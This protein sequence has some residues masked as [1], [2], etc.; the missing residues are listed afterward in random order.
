MAAFITAVV[1]A[2]QAVAAWIGTS[3]IAKTVFNIAASF[4]VSRLINKSANKS[5]SSS[6]G[7]RIQLPPQS[8]NKIPVLYGS[9]YINGI[10][11][12]ARLVSTDSK[13]NNVM[14][15][16][17]VLSE[18]TNTGTVGVDN[19]YWSDVK[20]VFES[21]NE[22]THKVLKGVKT[23]DTTD[24]Y[25]DNNFKSESTNLVQIRVYAGNTES[26]QQIFPQNNKVNAYDF[27]PTDAN[28]NKY[29]NNALYGGKV[30]M[31]GLVFAIVRV[32]YNQEKGIT[33]LPNITFKLNNTLNNPADVWYDYM[34]SNRYGANVNTAE[35]DSTALS[36]WRTH[37]NQYYN[38][39]TSQWQ[40]NAIGGQLPRYQ[41]N[42][43]VDTGNPVKN[44][45]DQILQ[46][47]AAWMSYD[48][49]AGL[50][51]VYP[52]APQ[53]ATLTFDD[54]NIVGGIEL[55]STNLEDLFNMLEVEYCDTSNFDQRLY[56]RDSIPV[57]DANN[58]AGTRHPNEPDNKLSMT[59]DLINNNIQA[60]RVGRIQLK[61]TRDDLVIRFNASHVGL[62]AQAGDV[63]YVKNSLYNWNTGTFANGKPFRITRVKEMETQDGALVVEITALE[64]NED[65]YTE[66]ATSAFTPSEN[67][68]IAPIV[69]IQQPTTPTIAVSETSGRPKITVTSVVPAGVV[70]AMEYWI[71]FDVGLQESQR[72]YKLMRV[73][74]PASGGTYITGTQVVFDFD[75]LDSSNLI[76]K[77]RGVNRIGAGPFSTVSATTTFTPKPVASV[78]D[79]N[80]ALVDSGGA[81]VGDLSLPTLLGKVADTFTA[82]DGNKT[83]ADK[84]FEEFTQK[85]GFDI[86]KAAT[87][88]SLTGTSG[89]VDPEPSYIPTITNV[90]PTT[91][92]YLGDT[93]VT[94]T[95]TNFI[96]NIQG[97]TIVTEL[98]WNDVVTATTSVTTTQIIFPVPASELGNN[99]IKVQTK[100]TRNGI[101]TTY[102][103]AGY[104]ITA[105]KVKDLKML[106]LYP[107]SRSRSNYTVSE[108]NLN[109]VPATGSYF[110]SY[111][112]DTELIV[113][114]EY[115][116]T[117]AVTYVES[118]PKPKPGD[119][120]TITFGSNTIL[121][122]FDVEILQ[123]ISNDGS[124][125]FNN[126]DK[127]LITN[128]YLNLKDRNGLSIS[129]QFSK[130]SAGTILSITGS[131]NVDN[132]LKFSV[133]AKSSQDITF[134]DFNTL[135]AATEFTGY[136]RGQFALTQEEEWY[137]M[138]DGDKFLTPIQKTYDSIAELQ[139]DVPPEDIAINQYARILADDPNDE[140]NNKIYLWD[141]E[142][143]VYQPD[144]LYGVI[145]T[146]F[147][148]SE[149][150]LLGTSNP[151]MRVGEY[152]MV[153]TETKNVGNGKVYKW[154]G[155]SKKFVYQPNIL[156]NF[157][158]NTNI[159]Q[160]LTAYQ[161]SAKL[162]RADGTLY[163]TKT[164]QQ[165]TIHNN[166][167]EIPFK[168]R[169]YGVDYYIMLDRGLVKSSDNVLSEEVQDNTTWTFTTE[170]FFNY[171]YQLI[172][173]FPNQGWN[174]TA[175]E[176]QFFGD[177]PNLYFP[178]KK[179]PITQTGNEVKGS[180]V[181][182]NNDNS[183]IKEARI[184]V[185]FLN[186]LEILSGNI[187][188][189]KIFDNTIIA[190]IPVTDGIINNN[191]AFEIPY[192]IPN[193]QP[194]TR[195][196]VTLPQGALSLIST[197]NDL[198]IGVNA[199]YTWTFKTM[200][201][202]ELL[203]YNLDSSKISDPNLEFVNR[204]SNIKLKFG[205]KIYKTDVIQDDTLYEMTGATDPGDIGISDTPPAGA[206]VRLY[207]KTRDQLVEQIDF[208]KTFAAN[209]VGVQYN[210]SLGVLT[211]NFTESFD[212]DTE[213]YILFNN[214]VYDEY[215]ETGDLGSTDPNAV[216]FTTDGVKITHVGHDLDIVKG[217]FTIGFNY[218][219]VA[220]YGKLRI[221]DLTTNKVIDEFRADDVASTFYNQA[222][223]KGVPYSKVRID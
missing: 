216:K 139:A 141:G 124:L 97:A 178:I 127:T 208:D 202:V 175:A 128:I 121:S 130:I 136:K 64:Y 218:P 210:S 2:V 100:A 115:Y 30:G 83:L 182:N 142:K 42:G 18:L 174:T 181:I 39:S 176:Q 105:I 103:S 34:T 7:G 63:V 59:L 191:G 122:Y 90:T 159:E 76:V 196:S 19:I 29:W 52:Q 32:E 8:N 140:D 94:V 12:D 180:V 35:I 160:A 129:N 70:E 188:V 195:Y 211:L 25:E 126:E 146:R 143:Y 106:D 131:N 21:A 206:W 53:A 57:Y 201:L 78:I 88:G 87:D 33:G 186:K 102:T 49:S 74:R 45:I 185:L 101:Q 192:I 177:A 189:K 220:G 72:S 65:V 215:W 20:L 54:N 75:S 156:K 84:V 217:Y 179:T 10:I 109:Y 173:A 16:C 77:Y 138:F 62:Q 119:N 169:E 60:L 117:L 80:T 145:I 150:E 190:T 47:S 22:D 79:V 56:A 214:L 69:D 92:D 212:C 41:I 168:N 4:L 5:K 36:A 110:V 205:R 221:T 50:W 123:G 222:G 31:Q 67:V 66:E 162:Y 95:G 85:T 86:V 71:T 24:D 114:N 172:N 151:V 209:N 113:P 28:N 23:V 148:E 164:Y 118:G 58:P 125:R 193:I 170:L 187:V 111:S 11:T 51:R 1:T 155:N 14:Y 44:N 147:F 120:L 27:W 104:V 165:I 99:T 163:D 3:F 82:A 204:R 68:G 13:T 132:P 133:T 183:F 203:E 108:K 194:N 26:A 219:V 213:Y 157:G 134:P 154:M 144:L 149:Q 96:P 93:V 137:V 38:T 40:N 197:T 98:L 161:G 43:I 48:I 61:Q 184:T 166:V 89:V 158:F 9:A 17:L 199:A 81:P 207:R 167:V 112:Y 37:C 91:V 171:Y 46:N 55:S 135:A 15:Y 107:P 6:Q 198:P 116:V 223:T 153:K 152:A 73:E 200:P